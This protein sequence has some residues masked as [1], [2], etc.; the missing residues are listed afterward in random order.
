MSC[1]CSMGAAIDIIGL[2]QHQN[3]VAR[4]KGISVHEEHV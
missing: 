3:V 1:V 4:Y 2:T